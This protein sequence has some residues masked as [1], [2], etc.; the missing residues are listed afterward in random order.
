MLRG[1]SRGIVGFDPTTIPGCTVWFDAADPATFGLSGTSLQTWR[2]K[3]SATCTATYKYN[4]PSVSTISGLSTIYFNGVSTMMTTNSIASYGAIETTWITCAVNLTTVSGSTPADAC[5][6]IATSGAGAERAIRYT[7][8]VNSTAYSINTSVTRQ[9]IGDNTNGVRGFIDTAAYFAGFTNGSLITSNTTAVTFQAG[10]NQSF[11]MGQ[12]NVG[13]LNGYVYEILIYN[14]A[15]TL[16]EYQ[17]VEGYL[18]QKW[19]FSPAKVFTPLSIP[20]CSIW[21]DAADMSSL[22][23]S[24]TNITSWT[25]KG[26]IPLVAYPLTGGL[27]TPVGGGT[28]SNAYGGFLTTG[29]SINGLNAVNCPQQTTYGMS[30]TVTFPTQARAVFAVY[31][32]ASAGAA[33]YITFFG[34]LTVVPNNQNGMANFVQH[35]G[36]GPVLFA[37]VGSGAGSILGG[38]SPAGTFPVNTTGMIGWVQSA[39]STGSNFVTMN[40]VPQSIT[41]NQLATTYVTTPQYYFIGSAYTQAYTFCEY[42]MF[43]SEISISQR[44]AVEG[45]LAWK[46]GIQ[47]SLGA[48]HPNYLTTGNFVKSLT[49]A[50]THPFY[51]Q[52]PQTRAFTPIDIP[53]C[54]LWLDGADSSAASMT[55]SSTTI[56]VWKDKSQNAYSFA[57][58]A[59]LSTISGF[60]APWF[61]Y[62][63]TNPLTYLTCTTLSIPQPYTVFAVGYSALNGGN[64]RMVNGLVGGTYDTSLFIGSFGSN[65][66]VFTGNGSSWNSA[67]GSLYGIDLN[68]WSITAAVISNANVN[69]YFN[70]TTITPVTGSYTPAT[71]TGLNV[72]GGY[73]TLTNLANTNYQ[74]WSGSIGEILFYSGVLT[75][76]QRQSIEGYLAAKWGLKA[77]LP[78]FTSPL[79][80]PGCVI[81]LDGADATTFTPAS[82]ATGA[83]ITAWK[84]KVSQYSFTPGAIQTQSANGTSI[85]VA[86]PTYVAGGGVLFTNATQAVGNGEQGLGIWGSSALFTVPTQ[87]MT[88]VVVSLPTAN[89]TL[90]TLAAVGSYPY[91]GTTKFILSPEM[92]VAEGGMLL[93]DNVQLNYTTSGYNTST[94]LRV[95]VMTSAPG[96]TQWWWTNGT[97]NTF[98]NSSTYTSSYTNYPVNY[99]FLGSYTNTV[100]GSR[101][102]KGNIYEVLYYNT[103]LTTAQQQLVE[104]YVA[105]KWGFRTSLP[106]THPFYAAAPLPHSFNKVPPT[107]RQPALYYDVAPGNW[108]R[109]WQ[110]YLKALAAANATGVSVAATNIS[111]SASGWWG[112]V[113]ASDGNI[114]FTPYNASNILKLNVSTGVTTTITGGATYTAS[115]WIGGVLGPDGNIYFCPLQATNILKLNVATGVT[116]NITGGATYTSYGW[117]GGVLGSDGNIYFTPYGASNILKLNVTTGVTTNITGGATFTAYG[118]GGGV[119]G[120]DGNI[121][122]SPINTG[123]ILKLN[124]ATGVT[125]NITGGATYTTSNGCAGGVLGPDGN[126]Y[127]TPSSAANILKLNVATGV[128]TTITGGAAYTSNGWWGG[129]LGADGNIYFTP[130]AATNILKLNVAT[131]VTT[132]I[133]GGATYTSLGWTGGVLGPDGNIYFCPNSATNIMKL[134]FSGLSQ[135]PSLN[136]CRSAYASKL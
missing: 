63:N 44:Q 48:T 47:G 79:S 85:T 61:N 126:I 120:P 50:T 52:I 103:A 45:Y 75:T 86:G 110:P 128:T 114:Y 17:S 109:D 117:L 59:V 133:T 111:V 102:F 7:F 118:W 99:F 64:T 8:N 15:L 67:N 106:S 101:N 21:F 37:E 73:E 35:D 71:L 127:F 78:T 5:P 136:Y 2:S 87:S 90:R 36:Q 14:R 18:A 132:N 29:A 81:W 82:P 57:G 34:C 49:L 98:T 40:G 89:D 69:G 131:G 1:T 72:G 124:V 92:G 54:A 123:N 96:A 122:F 13:W 4:A 130:Y 116:T 51:S 12:W 107:V 125:T 88:L 62:A 30:S 105:W 119:L 3:G 16:G 70:G 135:I 93:F 23:T 60:S 95:D 22:T 6:V 68:V 46:W 31:R 53:G 66:T 104:G 112:G 113:V 39:I 41:T 11:V 83:T 26:S 115:G 94:V 121:Y 55:V 108:A 74:P 84:D 27:G 100:I 97:V 19:G 129:V 65:A 58:T 9:T 134:T 42:I 33:P 91:S 43:N 56:S 28:N 20:G 38:G 24:G 80:I 10:V 76:A 25:N 77:Q 32:A